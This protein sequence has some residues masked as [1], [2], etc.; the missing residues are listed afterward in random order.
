[1]DQ[2][3][4]HKRSEASGKDELWD[5]EEDEE[6]VAWTPALKANP[7]ALGVWKRAQKMLAEA[8]K[9]MDWYQQLAERPRAH[10][11][12]WEENMVK[13]GDIDDSSLPDTTSGAMEAGCKDRCFPCGSTQHAT[14]QCSAPGGHWINVLTDKTMEKRGMSEQA[15]F[16]M[17]LVIL[18][19]INPR[20]ARKPGPPRKKRPRRTVPKESHAVFS[21]VPEPK[22]ETWLPGKDGSQKQVIFRDI[23]PAISG[24][25]EELED[26]EAFEASVC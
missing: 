14:S 12:V 21:H 6:P 24:R 23:I 18:Q 26:F 9:E 17:K 10:S 7:E 20:I 22:E 19:K 2:R 15:E 5:K 4:S 25:F 16:Q 3:P 1:M 11:K 13:S 8:C